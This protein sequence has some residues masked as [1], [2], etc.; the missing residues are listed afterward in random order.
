MHKRFYGLSL[1][2]LCLSCCWN[3]TTVGSL[4]ST[5]QSIQASWVSN[6]I[7]QNLQCGVY[8]MNRFS[9]WILKV[10][11]INYSNYRYKNVLKNDVN[12]KEIT[13]KAIYL[14]WLGTLTDPWNTVLVRWSEL[15]LPEVTR[16][17]L[18]SS[19]ATVHPHR[20][21]GRSLFHNR[22]QEFVPGR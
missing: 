13:K 9:L 8:F 11:N 21:A 1:Q 12:L 16:I 4:W 3:D 5:C 2:R 17:L 18:Y 19:C 10:N 6:W 22:T 15:S 7:M 20:G 14:V